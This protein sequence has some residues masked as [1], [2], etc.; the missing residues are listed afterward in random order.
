MWE[1]DESTGDY[2]GLAGDFKWVSPDGKAEAVLRLQPS[3]TWWHAAHN[4]RSHR[5]EADDWWDITAFFDEGPESSVAGWDMAESLGSWKVEPIF[6]EDGEHTDGMGV[7]LQCDACKWASCDQDGK[8]SETG[9]VEVRLGFAVRSI[10]GKQQLLLR[11]VQ[12]QDDSCKDNAKRVL[13]DLGFAKSYRRVPN[14]AHASCGGAAA[15]DASERSARVEDAAEEPR[16]L[17]QR[18]SAPPP[19]A[20]TGGEAS[21]QQMPTST[22]K[23]AELSPQDM[24]AFEEDLPYGSLDGSS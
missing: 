5:Q 24:S 12:G 15:A 3:G 11:T 1:A 18:G 10:S 21:R 17:R 2:L 14:S 19:D 4:Q 6:D 20:T 9:E 13:K 16:A 23:G 22:A 8:T 7:V